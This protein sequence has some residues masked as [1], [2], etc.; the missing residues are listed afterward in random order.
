RQRRDA[1]RR[2]P[3]VAN[4]YGITEAVVHSSWRALRRDDALVGGTP[5]GWALASARLDVLDPRDGLRAMP[6]GVAGEIWVGGPAL[7]RGYAGDPRATALRFGPDPFAGPDAPGARRYRSGDR[8]ER[9]IDGQIVVRGRLDRQLAIR[10][11]RVEPAMIERA[12]RIHPA[13]D[14]AAALGLTVDGEPLLVAAWTPSMAASPDDAGSLD[15][16]VSSEDAGPSEE[17]LRA[18]MRRRLP[19]AM[20]P[21][22]LLRL[23][24]D[25][26]RTPR[27]KVDRAMLATLVR[28]RLRLAATNRDDATSA[29][30]PSATDDP[31]LRQLIALWRTGLRTNAPLDADADLFAHGGTSLAAARIANRLQASLGAVVHVVSVL[32]HP[33]PRALLTFLRRSAPDA[34]ARWRI[35]GDGGSDDAGSA[36][37]LDASRPTA[38]GAVVRSPARGLARLAARL[39]RPSLPAPRHAP[40]R[41]L[42]APIFVLAPPRSGTTLLRTMLAGHPQL[43][44]PPEMALF[45]HADLASRQRTYQGRLRFWRDGL[46]HAVLAAGLAGPDARDA[47]AWI[48]ARAAAGDDVLALADR[49]RRAIAPRQLVDKTP[50]YAFD[51]A[52]LRRLIAAYPDAH[53]LHLSRDPRAVAHSFAEVR[54][55]QLFDRSWPDVVDGDHR[56]LG[57]AL[58]TLGHR[59]ILDALASVDAARALHVRYEDLVRA[60]RRTLR[61]IAGWLDLPWDDALLEPYDDDSRR[62]TH[63]L[64]PEGRTLGDV[65][66]AQHG[67]ITSARIARWR[68]ADPAADARLTAEARRLAERLGHALTVRNAPLPARS[69]PIEPTPVEPASARSTPTE[70]APVESASARSTPPE[71]ASV[72]PASAQPTPIEPAS[73]EPAS[74]RSAPTEPAPVESASAQPAPIESTPVQPASAQPTPAEPTP[75]ESTPAR[76]ASAQSTTRAEPLDVALHLEALAGPPGACHLALAYDVSGPLDGRALRLACARLIARHPALRRTL[77][78]TDGAPDRADDDA[79]FVYR[80]ASPLTPALTRVDL[81]A[82]DDDRAQRRAIARGLR[83]LAIRRFDRAASPPRRFALLRRA[84]DRAILTLVAHHAALDGWALGIVLRDLG[85]DYAAAHAD[86]KTDAPSI[87]AASVRPTDRASDDDALDAALARARARLTPLPPRLALPTDRP[88]GAQR[89]ADSAVVATALPTTAAGDALGVRRPLPI[90]LAAFAALAARL[91]GR[92]D[93]IVGVPHARRDRLALEDEVA[94]RTNVLPVRLR[95]GRVDAL[96]A[97]VAHAR[98]A[99]DAAERDR[100]LPFGRLVQM[101]RPPRSPGRTPLIDVLLSAQDAPMT[102]ALDDL[103]LTPRALDTP[104]PPKVDWEIDLWPLPAPRGGARHAR[105]DLRITL[106]YDP[107]L[108]DRTT[109]LRTLRGLRAFLRAAAIAPDAPWRDLPVHDAAARHALRWEHAPAAAA[110]PFEALPARVLAAA[111]RWPDAP[112]VTRDG[113]AA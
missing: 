109:A 70:P 58:W 16:A 89:P 112:A 2:A 106:R 91:S 39:R 102:P 36:V 33:T 26:P 76:S 3:T 31:L 77:H 75:A 18:H 97:L 61:R 108:F 32:D 73:V 4:L 37:A 81:D 19:T 6:I 40:D 57:S 44:A 5:V 46:I 22:R 67:R 41:A 20:V 60:P 50:A 68:T 7:A 63:S 84:P 45:D 55:E 107:A 94:C 92:G 105:G 64:A 30:M 42:P 88:R 98:D 14:D 101:L 87:A 85:R 34:L 15:D 28:L 93:L 65:R 24:D 48:D 90:V 103:T 111:A 8:G 110:A 29:T 104:I 11:H 83:R 53:F 27:G 54:L 86:L 52:T 80:A 113:D 66:F 72:Q 62:M 23:T 59:H 74:A 56:A 10:G 95:P 82:L 79:A 38:R 100:A 21:R 17:T 71:P 35:R 25:L 69:T 12:L 47:D 43:F 99:L 78:R 9:R 96:R 51:V 1:G 49:L 13:V